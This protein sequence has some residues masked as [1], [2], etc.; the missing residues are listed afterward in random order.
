M[1]PSASGDSGEGWQTTDGRRQTTGTLLCVVCRPSSFCLVADLT[2]LGPDPKPSGFE[3]LACRFDRVMI[4]GYTGSDTSS[5]LRFLRMSSVAT[6][7]EG[8]PTG[9]FFRA[10]NPIPWKDGLA[11]SVDKG[12][13]SE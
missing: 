4:C 2:A 8:G 1:S 13:S 3:A 11:L 10:K 7:P 9:G 12:V 5:P 6:L